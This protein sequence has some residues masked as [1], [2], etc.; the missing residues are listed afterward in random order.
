VA[1]RVGWT[2]RVTRRARKD[3]APRAAFAQIRFSFHAL[4]TKAQAVARFFFSLFQ[5]CAQNF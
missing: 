5:S 4:R 1:Q 2:L 3:A